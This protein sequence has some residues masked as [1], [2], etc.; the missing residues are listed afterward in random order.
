MCNNSTSKSTRTDTGQANCRRL[1]RRT[2]WRPGRRRCATIPSQRLPGPRTFLAS[3]E[4]R[5]G[6]GAG[7]CPCR[8]G[9]DAAGIRIRHVPKQLADLE[10][11]VAS[12]AKRQSDLED[13]ELEVMEAVEVA[14]AEHAQLVEQSE[15]VAGELAEAVAARDAAL[16]ELDA[17]LTDLQARRAEAVAGI[18][19]ELLALYVKIRDD[20]GGIAAAL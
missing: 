9:L 5:I 10:H 18:P 3:Y 15:R 2:S 13:A 19:A 6:C 8:A 17:D 12:L 4:G 7:P 16:A 14:E 11:E 1:S 20:R